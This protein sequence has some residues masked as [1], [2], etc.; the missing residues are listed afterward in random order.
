M[1]DHSHSSE[2]QAE[3]FDAGKAKTLS[4]ASAAVGVVGLLATLGLALHNREQFAFS[5]L[6]AFIYFFTICVGALFWTLVH[7]ATDAEWSVLVRRQLENVAALIP[8]LAIFFFAT[9]FINAPILYKWWTMHHGDS[10]LLDKKSAFLNPLAFTI[11]ALIYFGALG[12]LAYRN[13]ENSVGQDADGNPAFTIKMRRLAFMGIPALALSLTFASVDWLMSLDFHWQ[14][15]MWGVYLFAGGAG[16]AMCLL[17]LIVTALKSAGYLKLVN[18]EHYHIMGKLMLAFCVFWAYIGFS[19]YMLIWY[20]NMPEETSYYIR[21][22]TETWWYLSLGL[23]VFRFF[24]PFPFLLFQGSKKNPKY[25][26]IVAAW[27]LAMQLL[28]MYI[29]VMPMLH[30]TGVSLSLL[31]ITTVLGIGGILGF[32][33]LNRLPKTNLF[34]IRDPRIQESIRLTN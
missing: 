34:P 28:D 11:R 33:F 8:V 31:D 22:T 29:I 15:T 17:V 16:S 12:F 14:S 32:F 7:H 3:Q 24:L 19:Q 6:F 10:E 5:W 25:L 1:S 4:L 21:R 23:V 26:C 2:P 30:Q 20:A 18:T 27:I 9:V 13:R